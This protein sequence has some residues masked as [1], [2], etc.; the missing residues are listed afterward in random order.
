MQSDFAYACHQGSRTSGVLKLQEAID[1]TCYKSL[2]YA[3]I[4]A[5]G[6]VVLSQQDV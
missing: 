3:A 4:G 6:R 5:R 1:P 2:A